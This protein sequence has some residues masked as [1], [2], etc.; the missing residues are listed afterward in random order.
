M[1][2][3]VF[4]GF[5]ASVGWFFCG[6]VLIVCLFSL[7]GVLSSFEVSCVCVCVS[8]LFF[9]ESDW[10]SLDLRSETGGDI[11]VSSLSQASN[12]T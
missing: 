7:A 12:F 11:V 4:L 9:G 1:L 5:V 3:C 8:V 6:I 2:L 10:M